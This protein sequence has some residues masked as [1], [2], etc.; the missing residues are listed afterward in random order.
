MNT[1]TVSYVF[2]ICRRRNHCDGKYMGVG[3]TFPS[4]TPDLTDFS[5]RFDV[6][7]CYVRI[8]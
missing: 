6:Y 8:A 2:S 7:L 1:A 5:V 4:K 3:N